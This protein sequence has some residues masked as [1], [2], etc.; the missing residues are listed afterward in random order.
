LPR[1]RGPLAFLRLT[2][3]AD[4]YPD[5]LPLERLARAIVVAYREL[6]EISEQA[7]ASLTLAP[8]TGGLVRCAL[9][10]G[11]AE[12]NRRFA[13]ALEEA[14]N[15]AVGQRYVVSRPI[16]PAGRGRRAV[17]W[18]ALTFRAPLDVAW[19]PVP[20][21]LGSHKRRA[22]VYLAAYS[23]HLGPG[24]LLFAGREGAAGRDPLA[25]A[26]AADPQFVTSRRQLWH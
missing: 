6:G 2:A 21:D 14:L 23:A 10:D 25:A 18:R 15:P 12:E 17:A 26:A 3:L 9:A 8:R 24:T 22:D 13:N 11:D 20:S 19:H 1:P 5:V 16:W 4:A 7:A